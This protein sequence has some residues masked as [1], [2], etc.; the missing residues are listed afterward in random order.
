M[1]RD[2]KNQISVKQ[3]LE[4]KSLSAGATASPWVDMADVAS[5]VFA[6][7]YGAFTKGS[8]T[9]P[10]TAKIQECD[11]TAAADAAD[12]A[13]ADLI[14]SLA[15]VKNDASDDQRSEWVGYKGSKRYARLVVTVPENATS[16]LCSAD[17]II[18]RGDKPIAAVTTAA[19]T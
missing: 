14:G 18:G 2:L 1:T 8:A 9:D 11:T 7:N 12:V 16:L 15:G 3:I 10:V 19:A 5:I 6:V 17:A 13:A 4:A